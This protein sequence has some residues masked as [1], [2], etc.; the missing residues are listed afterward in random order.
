MKVAA[1]RS[2]LTL[3]VCEFYTNY[4]AKDSWHTSPD[5]F[6][7]SGVAFILVLSIVS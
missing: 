4:K 5:F 1:R 6:L 3:I 2:F 7:L